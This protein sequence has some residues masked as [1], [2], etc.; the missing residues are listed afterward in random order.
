MQVE[1][2]C[3]IIASMPFREEAEFVQ[4]YKCKSKIMVGDLC[5]SPGSEILTHHYCDP[6]A[7]LK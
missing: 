6:I 1:S 7:I 2:V 5:L 3:T 4:A